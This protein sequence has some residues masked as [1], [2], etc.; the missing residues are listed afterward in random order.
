[1][2]LVD[3]NLDFSFDEMDSSALLT[4]EASRVL[5]EAIGEMGSIHSVKLNFSG[6]YALTS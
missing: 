1:M 4:N 2:N 3:I 6:I 5:G